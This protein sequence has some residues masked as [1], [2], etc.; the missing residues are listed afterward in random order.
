VI[1]VEEIIYTF[2]MFIS[3]NMDDQNLSDEQFKRRFGV[4]KQTYRK[5]VES[6]KSLETK[7]ELLLLLFCLLT[8]Y[9]IHL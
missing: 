4:Y 9:L 8:F 3:K 6:V 5:M 2:A 1:L 7:L